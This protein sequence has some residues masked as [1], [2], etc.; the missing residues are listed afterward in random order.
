MA[1]ITDF[2]DLR[3]LADDEVHS[4]I[5][6]YVSDVPMHGSC[7]IILDH[8]PV[9]LYDFLSDM[10]MVVN[11]FIYDLDEYRVFLGRVS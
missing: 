9:E 3:A 4:A 7:W 2:L 6:K 8:D 5:S 10:G 1:V 11:T